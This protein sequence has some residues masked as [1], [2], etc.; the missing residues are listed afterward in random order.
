MSDFG[1]PPKHA[2]KCSLNH[3][4]ALFELKSINII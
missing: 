1:K 3:L 2:Q 4:N